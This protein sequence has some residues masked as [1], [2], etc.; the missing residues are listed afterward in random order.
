[1]LPIAHGQSRIYDHEKRKTC[2]ILAHPE[3]HRFF[4]N[5]DRSICIIIIAD[6]VD[7][8]QRLL[9]AGADPR[10]IINSKGETALHHLDHS[11]PVKCWKL[12]KEKCNLTVQDLMNKGSATRTPLEKYLAKRNGRYGALSQVFPEFASQSQVLPGNVELKWCTVG[13]HF[14][15]AEC[16]ATTVTLD[17]IKAMRTNG[18][19]DHSGCYVMNGA[20]SCIKCD[21]R[22]NLNFVE[23]DSDSDYFSD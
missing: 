5:I 6:D 14:I 8:L 22:A 12:L 21:R 13:E 4:N 10:R 7:C 17:E 16:H 11:F 15:C 1:M 20:G 3:M 9:E 19:V 18:H 2:N 23:T